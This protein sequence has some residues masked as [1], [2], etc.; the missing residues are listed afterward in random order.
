MSSRTKALLAIFVA[1]VFWAS[2]GAVA[3]LLLIHTSP[4]V[5]VA[6]RFALA[7]VFI[8]PF[9]LRE[10]KPGG[11]FLKLLPLGI[12]NAGNVFF[13]YT[14][15]SLTT[16]NTAAVLG[17]AVPITTAAF[18]WLLIRERIS[19]H[20][21]IGI[22]VGLI[23]ALLITFLPIWGGDT[24]V[25][26]NFLGNMLLIG[27]VLSWTLYIIYLR[28]MLSSRIFSPTLST[29]VNLF[30]VTGAATAVAFIMGQSLFSPSVF[31]P[32]YISTLIYA[33]LGMTVITFFLFQ[34]G[35]QHVSATTASLKEYLQL[36]IGVGINAVILGERFTGPYFA[37]SLLVALGVFI[38]TRRR[39]PRNV[40]I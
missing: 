29:S 37:G 24:A 30:V 17:A 39:A 18:S 35:V 14:G 32:S 5:A 3:K 9:F 21:L 26:G 19:Q 11:Y 23:G 31:V 1:S 36:V 13:Y 4:F 6:H 8:L 33:S 27:S 20:K 2:A 28:H 10:K 7:S 38:A 25:S 34:W 15:L 22:V 16:A 40:I 12:F